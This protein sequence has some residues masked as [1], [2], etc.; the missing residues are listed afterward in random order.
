VVEFG[1]A[2]DGCSVWLI[3]KERAGDCVEV[4]QL[5]PP[6][7]MGRRNPAEGVDVPPGTLTIGGTGLVERR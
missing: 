4:G 7:P 6:W 1:K 5:G 2:P 3:D